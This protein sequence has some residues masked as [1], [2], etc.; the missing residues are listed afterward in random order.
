SD[1]EATCGQVADDR[2]ADADSAA[3]NEDYRTFL[4]VTH[5]TDELEVSRKGAKAQRQKELNHKEHE[6]HKERLKAEINSYFILLLR[7]LS[8]LCG[9]RLCISLRL[10]AFA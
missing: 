7:D 2:G 3:G 5:A 6:G 8:V 9:K 10:R 1:L 4:C